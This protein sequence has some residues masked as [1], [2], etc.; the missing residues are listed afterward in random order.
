MLTSAATASA[1]ILPARIFQGLISVGSP[2]VWTVS[3]AQS[4]V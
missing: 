1:R 4:K 3:P 2:E